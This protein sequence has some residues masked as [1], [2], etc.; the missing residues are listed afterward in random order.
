MIDF[1][2]NGSTFD[3]DDG[4]C[5]Y[6]ETDTIRSI[7]QRADSDFGDPLTWTSRNPIPDFDARIPNIRLSS[8]TPLVLTPTAAQLTGGAW[9]GVMTVSTLGSKANLK[10]KDSLGHVGLSQFISFIP[11]GDSDG[12]GLSNA[13]ELS[14]GLNPN[15]PADADLDSDHDGLSNRKEFLAGTD[16]LNAASRLTIE[17]RRADGSFIVFRFPTIPGK[18]Y[19]IET[20]SE[21]RPAAWLPLG[22]ISPGTGGSIE[23]THASS[24]DPAAFFRLKVVP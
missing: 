6:T 22:E 21:P 8:L 17:I 5:R 18:S 19:Q 14:Y 20:A 15:N 11:D 24:A 9:S 12:D 7:F 16:P 4:T 23:I 10:A 13:F 1:C 3:L 2:F